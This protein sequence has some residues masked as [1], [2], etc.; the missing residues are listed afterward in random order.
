MVILMDGLGC[1]TALTCEGFQHWAIVRIF[2]FC[3][4]LVKTFVLTAAK[5]C[6]VRLARPSR[7]ASTI[8]V[9]CDYKGEDG[10]LN[11]R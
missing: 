11:L 2:F 7:A 4:N 1:F 9:T 8:A 5:S 3:E 10:N 6:C